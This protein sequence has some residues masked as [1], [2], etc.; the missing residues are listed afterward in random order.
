MSKP[1]LF[2]TMPVGAIAD[3]RLT[4]LEL[5]CLMVISLHDGMSD[6]KGSGGGCYARSSTLAKL[7]RTDV[8]NFSKAVSRLAKFGYVA[9]E[10][11]QSDRRRYTLRVL[12][13]EDDTWRT[14]QVSGGDEAAE[15]VG[16]ATNHRSEIVGEPTTY[17]A[18]IVGEG[19]RENGRIPPET[20]PH[21]IPLNGELNS[22]ESGEL[23]SVKTARFA[24]REM[25]RNVVRFP[26]DQLPQGGD[27][28]RLGRGSETQPQ[29]ALADVGLSREALQ[30]KVRDAIAALG[31]ARELSRLTGVSEP[32]IS[33]AR[34]AK[35]IPVADMRRLVAGIE[36]HFGPHLEERGPGVRLEEIVPQ[37]L[38]HNVQLCRFERDMARLDPAELTRA[39]DWLFE[40]AETYLG[41]PTGHHAQRLYEALPLPDAAPTTTLHM[42]GQ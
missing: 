8:S 24:A 23:N 2:T 28:A 42:E 35:A 37:D 41:E 4:A 25:G 34:Y 36:R 32:Y 1:R 18:E 20:A 16:E 38:P 14:D 30:I 29:P 26:S 27:V 5:R 11:Q 13:P 17:D 39:E 12:F 40:I 10:A 9:R 33:R 3:T 21:Y 15:I 7:A 22:E 31:S 19:E 6:L